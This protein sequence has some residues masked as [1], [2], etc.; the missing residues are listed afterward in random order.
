MVFGFDVVGF[1][2]A[3]AAQ[4]LAD[5]IT[6]VPDQFYRVNGDYLYPQKYAPYLGGVFFSGVSTPAVCQVYQPKITPNNAYQFIKSVLVGA[7]NA[8]PGFTDLSKRPLKLMEDE[9]LAVRAINATAEANLIALFLTAG[10][11]SQAA[12]DAVSPTHMLTGYTATNCVAGAWTNAVMVWDQALP[13]GEYCVVGMKASLAGAGN[14]VVRLV[15]PENSWHPGVL[16]NISTVLTL[17]TAGPSGSP[18]PFEHWP[19][20]PELKF[21]NVNLP[22]IQMLSG[23]VDTDGLFEL[24]L[25]KVS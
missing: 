17:N 11:I 22:G 4:T 13:K 16:A 5:A 2:E 24:M 25:Q 21:S 12:L 15:F 7:A 18:E 20:M 14:G 3:A 10:R 1:Y 19:L 6:P 23:I 9:Q 8:H